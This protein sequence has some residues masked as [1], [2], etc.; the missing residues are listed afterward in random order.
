MGVHGGKIADE[1]RDSK[2]TTIEKGNK[3]WDKCLISTRH[4]AAALCG[5]RSSLFGYGR[6][7]SL[8]NTYVIIIII[9]GGAQTATASEAFAAPPILC[10]VLC[11]SR[12]SLLMLPLGACAT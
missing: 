10:A 6:P 12:K 8:K 3:G 11:L 5:L 4:Q 2:Q 7:F 9:I 1:E